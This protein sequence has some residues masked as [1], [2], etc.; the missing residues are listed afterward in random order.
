MESYELSEREKAILRYVIHQFILTANPVGSRN[1]AKKY[2]IGWSPATIRNIMADL[3]ESGFL[4]HPHT[5]AGRLPTDRGYRVYVDSLMDPPSLNI[6]DKKIIDAGFESDLGDTDNLLKLTASILSD[7]TK[8]LACVTYPKFD[9]AILKKIQIVQLSSSRLLV[10][11]SIKSGFVKTIT[12]E[13]DAEVD[14]DNIHSVQ[15]FLNER[16]SGLKL[17]ELRKTC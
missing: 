12:L 7:I 1:I 11:V 10:V 17:S 6:I 8:Q 9:E 15:Q 14:E 2:E 3:E 5:S 4:R 16:L 13:I